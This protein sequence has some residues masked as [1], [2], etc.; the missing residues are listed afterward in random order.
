[1]LCIIHDLQFICCFVSQYLELR[2]SKPVR[3]CGTL[4][5][6]FQTVGATLHNKLGMHQSDF[7]SPNNNSNTSIPADTE[8]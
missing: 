3:I 1:M 6:I 5:F 4:T 2:F 8:Y 7:F